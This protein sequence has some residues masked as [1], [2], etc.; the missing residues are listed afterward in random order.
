MLDW[1][2]LKML[3]KIDLKRN[4]KRV[5]CFVVSLVSLIYCVCFSTNTSL[6]VKHFTNLHIQSLLLDSTLV[7]G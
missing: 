6:D 5:M 3:K 1:F 2:A 4:T 7:N